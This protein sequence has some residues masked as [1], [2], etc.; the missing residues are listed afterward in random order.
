M[1]GPSNT[2]LIEGT[3]EELSEELAQYLDDVSKKQNPDATPIKPEVTPLLTQ[4]KKDDVLKKLVTASSVLN[5]APERA[6]TMKFAEFVAAYNLL[7]H[8]VTQSSR[9]EMFLPKMT[10]NLCAPF[11]TPNG[12]GLALSILTTVFNILPA[13]SDARYHVFLATLRVVRSSGLFETLRPQLK[14]LDGWIA[15]WET[16]EEDQRS[17]FLQISDVAAEVGDEDESYNYLLRA[18]RTIP[19]DEA[20]NESSHDLAIRALKAALTHPTH[21]SFQDL[22][23][24]DAIQA[25]RKSEPDWYEFLELFNAEQ[26]DDYNDFLESHDDFLEIGG[27]NPSLLLRKMRL[28]TLAS[29]AASTPSRSLPYQHI[30]KALQI[31]AEDVEM[32]VIDVIRAGLVEGKL[33]V[34]D[35]Q[36]HVQGIWG[37]AVDG[38]AGAT[39]Y[40]EGEFGGGLGVIKGERMKMLQERERE[41]KEVD[42]KVNGMMGGGGATMGR[43]RGVRTGFD[44]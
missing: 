16:D 17:L 37:E 13:N 1:P 12:P 9:A 3:F 30:A 22:T 39:G 40:V 36:E 5:N 21:F 8:L 43:G 24:C 15:L 33:N 25:L 28:L 2:L 41:A 35:S 44:D 20:A 7:V 38:G 11:P 14:N 19:T 23:V 42:G 4:E 31:S 6:Y 26:L 32:W 29:L 10:Q 18:L 34:L 27:L